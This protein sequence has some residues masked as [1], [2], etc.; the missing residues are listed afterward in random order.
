MENSLP[1]LPPS[2]LKNMANGAVKRSTSQ[3]ERCKST[4]RHKDVYTG[5]K[6]ASFKERVDVYYYTEYDIDNSNKDSDDWSSN[7]PN[8]AE[9]RASE[10][11]MCE[12]AMN[13]NTNH[14]DPATEIRNPAEIEHVI[15]QL[16]ILDYV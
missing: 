6:R 3:R 5:P 13:R 14:D 7:K 11:T 15:K 2:I 12:N 8:H 1:E 9:H 10:S 16:L 4:R